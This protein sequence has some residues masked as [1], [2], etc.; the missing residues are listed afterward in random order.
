MSHS[1]VDFTILVP[2]ITT[3][4]APSPAALHELGKLHMVASYEEGMFVFVGEPSPAPSEIWPTWML[5]IVAWFADSYPDQHWLRLDSDG[6]VVDGIPLF[7][8]F[9]DEPTP[10][11]DIAMVAHA[12]DL[13][14][15]EE[16]RIDETP[17]LARAD[18]AVW[19][20][21]WLRVS[22]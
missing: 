8:W 16:I 2:V 7:N 21:A 18:D 1:Q 19:V 14:E 17:A 5:P 4:H 11:S 13:Y 15:T 20:S 3:G 9:S 12:R 6:A 10:S 22:Y